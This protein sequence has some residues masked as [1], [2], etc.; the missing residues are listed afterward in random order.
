MSHSRLP[1]A[2][3]R[4]LDLSHR[5]GAYCTKLLADAGADVV[6]VEL[7]AGDMLRR[8]GPFIEGRDD[9]EASLT[10]AYYHANKR[11]VALDWRDPASVPS[12]TSLARHCHVVVL[13]PDERDRVAGFEAETGSLSWAPPD[14]VVCAITA[15]GTTGPYR[16]FR[17]TDFTAQALGGLMYTCGPASGAPVGMP[18]QQ[19]F[20]LAGTHAAV[21]VV[22]ALGRRREVGGQ[23]LDM[24]VHEV[25]AASSVELY[26]YTNAREI[27]RRREPGPRFYGGTFEAQDGPVEVT[28]ATDKHWRGLVD[29]LGEP[30]ALADPAWSV[31]TVRASHADVMASEIRRGLATMTR[32]EFVEA[33]QRRAIPSGPV[34]TVGE[35]ADDRHIQ[36]RGFIVA[37]DREGMGTLRLPGRAFRAEP[38]LLAPYRRPAPR[39]GEADPGEVADSWARSPA[40]TPSA[41]SLAGVRVLSFGTN[42]AGAL[43]ASYLAE[44]GADVVKV[45]SPIVPDNTRR[46]R[47]PYE[48]PV[49]EPSG[50]DTSMMY[51]NYNRSVRDVALD[52]KDPASFDTLLDLV[53]HAD[54]IVENFSPGVMERWGLTRERLAAVNADVVMVSLS[55]FGRTGPRG[56]YLLYGAITCAFVGLARV[57]G[58]VHQAHY[59]YVSAAHGT[60]AV[61]AA[62]AARDR[63]RSEIVVDLAQVEA[64][65]A[66]M[67]P[68]IAD[69][70]VNH[71]DGTAGPEGLLRTVVPCLGHDRWLAVELESAADWTALA[72]LLGQPDTAP[73]DPAALAEWARGLTATQAME[74]LQR[75]GVA[76]AAVQT[77]ED[78]ARDPQHRHRRFLVEVSSPDLGTTEWAAAPH[79]LRKTPPR[80]TGP[81][82]RLGQHTAEVFADWLGRNE[83]R[84]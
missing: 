29:L 5:M 13:S 48:R 76:A 36:E 79:R 50:A 18:G 32:E 28:I 72:E 61:L 65:G 26:H 33:A 21:A 7:P 23:F 19:L 14:A 81:A 16:A 6:K 57:W 73:P 46:S 42:I 31:P 39:L 44:L 54:V 75:A 64:A 83:D 63:A 47:A 77:G 15:C 78:V 3:V 74:R 25:A 34:N 17:A 12:L 66:L 30:E 53:A 4:V 80:V 11:G 55:G 58:T 41:L 59:D 22:A 82:P 51:A 24:S 37:H 56:H 71:R 10:F 2:G 84:T 8:A 60:F 52:A 1:L 38:P 20:D 69:Y 27:Q 35:F 49:R 40:V 70:L 9:A 68:A 45:E 43:C 62:L 67:G